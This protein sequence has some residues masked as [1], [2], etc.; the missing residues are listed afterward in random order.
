MLPYNAPKQFGKFARFLNFVEMFTHFRLLSSFITIFFNF[1]YIIWHT[2][3]II[4]ILHRSE[5][6][7]KG[8]M[9]GLLLY[10]IQYIKK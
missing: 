2:W 9:Y 3:R 7:S 6:Q 8:R 10:I 1:I 4:F 5:S